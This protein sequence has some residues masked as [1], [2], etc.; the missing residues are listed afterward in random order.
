MVHEAL[1][2]H[3][4]SENGLSRLRASTIGIGRVRS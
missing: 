1:Q 3:V 2:R 4:V